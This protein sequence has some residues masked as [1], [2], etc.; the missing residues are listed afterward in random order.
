MR[1]R[2]VFGMRACSNNGPGVFYCC[3]ERV[4]G[5]GWMLMVFATERVHEMQTHKQP[6]L[7]QLWSS[8]CDL[9]IGK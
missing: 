9:R 4:R 5:G 3:H 2:G 8:Q 1:Q 7:L 6:P